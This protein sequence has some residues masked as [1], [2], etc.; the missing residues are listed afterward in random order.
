MDLVYLSDGE[1][2]GGMNSTT[3]YIQNIYFSLECNPQQINSPAC[4]VQA[5]ELIIQ[6]KNSRK[7]QARIR[8]QSSIS[9]LA[10]GSMSEDY[11][12]VV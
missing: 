11:G 2:I 12:I 1:Y 8:S 9:V 4:L 3:S 6:L 5:G 7:P 10:R